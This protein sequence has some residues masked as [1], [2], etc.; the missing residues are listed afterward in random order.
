MVQQD[1]QHLF[2]ALEHENWLRQPSTVRL[3]A[4]MKQLARNQAARCLVGASV[5]PADHLRCELT[6]AAATETLITRIEKGELDPSQL[7]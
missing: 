3:V 1:Q 4:Y 5:L 2:H 6:K 7:L